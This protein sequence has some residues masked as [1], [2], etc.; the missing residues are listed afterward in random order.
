MTLY[1]DVVRRRRELVADY[2]VFAADFVEGFRR[3]L[4][5]TQNAYRARKAAFDE[6]FSDRPYDTNGSGAYRWACALKRLDACDP[7]RLATIL[8]EAIGC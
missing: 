7:E 2:A 1:A 3:K 6:L 4:V 8:K 5:E